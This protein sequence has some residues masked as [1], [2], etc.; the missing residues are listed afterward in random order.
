MNISQVATLAQSVSAAILLITAVVL[1]VQ[2]RETRRSAYATAFKAIYE[3]LQDEGKRADRGFVMIEL[4]K[5]PYDTWTP[6]EKKRAERVCH[7]YDAV[8]IICRNHLLPTKLIADSWGD[9]L[10]RCWRILEPLVYE[11]RIARNA[12]EFWDD[13]QWLSKQAARY[14][15]RMHT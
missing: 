11:Y 13:F 8:G 7:N 10:R 4:S 2:V 6:D 5:K 14:Q 15:Q 3:M 9:S 1:W 12:N